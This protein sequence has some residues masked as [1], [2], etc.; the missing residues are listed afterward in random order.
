MI[1]YDNPESWGERVTYWRDSVRHEEITFIFDN[2]KEVIPIMVKYEDELEAKDEKIFA[3]AGFEKGIII[4]KNLLDLSSPIQ[5]LP[6][7]Y[8]LMFFGKG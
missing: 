6:L 4:T 5:K 8:F 3:H 7:G 2:G 1:R